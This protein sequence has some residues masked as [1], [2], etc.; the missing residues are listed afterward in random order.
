MSIRF[1]K[2]PLCLPSHQAVNMAKKLS[3]LLLK[4]GHFREDIE[5]FRWLDE[6]R[7]F[8]AINCHIIRE[9]ELGVGD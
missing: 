8:E 4:V 9:L 3:I 1:S 2:T 5:Y 6:A 7:L